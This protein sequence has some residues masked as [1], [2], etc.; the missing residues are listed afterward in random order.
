MQHLYGYFDDEQM[1]NYKTKLHKDVF[2]LLLYKDPEKINDFRNVD[3][4]KYFNSLMLKING[5]NTLLSF[6]TEIVEMM[7]VLEAALLET[8]RE[9]FNFKTYRKLIFDAH[10]LIDKIGG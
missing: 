2:W 5:L 3:Y 10:S 4:E 6:P 1:E 9:N 8:K 7:S